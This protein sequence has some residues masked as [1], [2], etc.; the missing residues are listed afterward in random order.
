MRAC[1]RGRGIFVEQLSKS[2]VNWSS[3]WMTVRSHTES[4]RVPIFVAA[5]EMPVFDRVPMAQATDS[6]NKVV[7][8]SNSTA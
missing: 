1:T 6:S 8:Q 3:L 7:G 4:V 5:E 2:L